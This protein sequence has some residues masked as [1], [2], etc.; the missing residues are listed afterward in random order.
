VSSRP[1]DVQRLIA[2]WVCQTHARHAREHQRG[3]DARYA[4]ADIDRQRLLD[5]AKA[6]AAMATQYAD[7][8]FAA[9]I[10]A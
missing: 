5:E 10:G 3:Y 9:S 1:R 6:A 8:D 7:T 4:Q 2:E